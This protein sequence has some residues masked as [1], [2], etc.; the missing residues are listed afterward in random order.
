MH[1]KFEMSPKPLLNLKATATSKLILWASC[2]P[3]TK[4]S[5]EEDNPH[6]SAS[7]QRRLGINLQL[8]RVLKGPRTT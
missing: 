8:E 7:A 2:L 4:A 3:Y 5:L 6:P 1:S